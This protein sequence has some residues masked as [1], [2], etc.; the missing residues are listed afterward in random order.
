MRG[1]I[2]E[3]E[4]PQK[5]YPFDVDP[6][7]PIFKQGITLAAGQEKDIDLPAAKVL[8]ISK[9]VTL[10]TGAGEISIAFGERGDFF[11]LAPG[12]EIH[13]THFSRVRFRNNN[14]VTAKGLEFLHTNDPNFTFKNFSSRGL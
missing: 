10:N 14:N 13:L 7:R 2:Q 6:D 12:D 1:D 3:Q 5:D 8:F 4:T 11:E 9:M